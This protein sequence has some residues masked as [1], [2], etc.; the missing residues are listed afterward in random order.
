MGLTTMAEVELGHLARGG[1]DELPD[2][3][4]EKILARL[5]LECLCR[6]PAVS[7]EWNALFSCPKFITEKWAE[8]P[9]NNV[10]QMTTEKNK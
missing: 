7:K 2:D 4:K 6:S 10:E 5:P 3:T 8:E 9:T 1:W